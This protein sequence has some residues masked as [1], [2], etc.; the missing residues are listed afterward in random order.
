MSNKS[1]WK[2]VHGTINDHLIKLES[3]SGVKALFK[4]PRDQSSYKLIEIANE[5]IVYQLALQLGIPI[6]Q[7]FVEY[8]EC[9]IGLISIIKS[10]LNWNTVTSQ[11]E[12]NKVTNLNLFKQ[13]FV[14]DLLCIVLLCF[15]LFCFVFKMGGN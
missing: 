1:H 15:V 10:E 6:S 7:T 4:Q 14:F 9:K 11:S 12:Q 5:L 3:N 13:L 2:I 8:I